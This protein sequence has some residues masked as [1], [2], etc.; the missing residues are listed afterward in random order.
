MKNFY[1]CLI[2][3]C[4]LNGTKPTPALKAMGLS[5][6]NLQKWQRQ[7]ATITIDTLEKVA[8]YFGVSPSYF[9]DEDIRNTEKTKSGLEELILNEISAVQTNL[10]RLE[11]LYNDLQGQK[12]R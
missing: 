4:E 7:E 5:A 10:N 8:E 3:L 2:E 12:V 6:G 1:K 9:F 11:K